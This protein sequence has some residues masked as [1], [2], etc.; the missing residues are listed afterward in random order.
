MVFSYQEERDSR[1]ESHHLRDSYL[2]NKMVFIHIGFLPSSSHN[3][4]LPL[5]SSK[6]LFLHWSKVC[7]HLHHLAASLRLISL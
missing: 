5:G 4:P 6:P 7:I 3:L 2:C 1:R